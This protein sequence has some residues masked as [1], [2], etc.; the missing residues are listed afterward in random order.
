VYKC[1]CNILFI[2]KREREYLHHA[3]RVHSLA[4]LYIIKITINRNFFHFKIY[5]SVNY[6]FIILFST[7][8]FLCFSRARHIYNSTEFLFCNRFSDYFKER[9][10]WAI[11]FFS[12]IPKETVK[13][14]PD[15]PYYAH[16]DGSLSEFY[17]NLVNKK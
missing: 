15:T 9:K 12:N 2:T 10:R 5:N 6:K 3:L 1:I 13:I 4:L 8:G 17:L 14:S 16:V 11:F 7:G